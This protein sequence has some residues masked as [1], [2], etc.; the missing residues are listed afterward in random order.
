MFRKKEL[1]E[2]DAEAI[3]KK[4]TSH[5]DELYTVFKESLKADSNIPNSIERA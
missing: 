2:K 3:I 5:Q 1:S 4:Y